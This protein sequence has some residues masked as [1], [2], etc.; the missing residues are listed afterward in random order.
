MSS[1]LDSLSF[2][3]YPIEHDGENA[4]IEAAMRADAMLVKRNTGT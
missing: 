3:N 4:K 1:D 2:G